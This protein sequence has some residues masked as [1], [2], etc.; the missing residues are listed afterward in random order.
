MALLNLNC[1]LGDAHVYFFGA[2]AFSFSDKVRLEN[3]DVMEFELA[4][5]GRALRNLIRVER[6]KAAFVEV[7]LL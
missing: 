2:D 7:K 1:N 6:A 3:G 4:G 5:F